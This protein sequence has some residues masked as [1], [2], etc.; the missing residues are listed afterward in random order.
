MSETQPQALVVEDNRLVR[1]GIA[2]LLRRRGFDVS[3]AENGEKALLNLRKEPPPAVIILDML[4]PVV[5]GWRFLDE[6]SHLKLQPST[7]IIVTTGSPA[8]DRAW[9]ADHGCGG[10][11]RKPVE[12][13]RLAEEIKRCLDKTSEIQIST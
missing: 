12:E 1:E 7:W 9:A 10:F 8:I 2:E 13:T 5:D 6:F 3:L 11:L 4:M